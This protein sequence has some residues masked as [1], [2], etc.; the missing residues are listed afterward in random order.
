MCLFIQFSFI[1]QKNSAIFSL[2]CISNNLKK[3]Q[4]YKV[5]K[6]KGKDIKNFHWAFGEPYFIEYQNIAPFR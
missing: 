3:I 5:T 4:S 6:N 2:S 1:L